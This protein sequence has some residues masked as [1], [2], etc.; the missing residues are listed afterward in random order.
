MSHGARKMSLLELTTFPVAAAASSSPSV[1]QEGRTCSTS[2]TCATSAH[3]VASCTSVSTGNPSQERTRKVGSASIKPDA[4]R[5][6]HAG[7]VRLVERGLVDEPHLGAPAISFSALA[8]SSACARLS[9]WQGPAIIEIGRSLP[10]LTWPAVTTGAASSFAFKGFSFLSG[11]DHAG[12]RSQD[13]PRIPPEYQG[14]AAGYFTA[15][16]AARKQQSG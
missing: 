15:E 6:R 13:Q 11:A 1:G 7:A 4:P 9:S 3:C 16:N 2:T 14:C 5:R 12:P 10:N 8:T